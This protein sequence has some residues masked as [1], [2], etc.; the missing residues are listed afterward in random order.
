MDLAKYS[1]DD[2]FIFNDQ[3]YEN[4]LTSLRN[5]QITSSELFLSSIT[6]V[7]RK[8]N[9]TESEI[10]GFID[11]Y[12]TET[13]ERMKNTLKLPMAEK[14]DDYEKLVLFTVG[15]ESI[16]SR[17]NGGIPL[18]YLIEISG[19][20]SCGK[21]NF[22]LTLSITIQLPLEFGGLGP[23]VFS[24]NSNHNIKTLYIP[25]ESP[26]PTQRLT[27][28]V[29][30]FGQLLE[31]NGI[32]KER[33]ECF[34][35]LDNVLTTSNVMTNLEEQ[36]H[37]LK[38][39]L[40]VML[41][42]DRS[43]KLLIIDSLTHH[44]RA[45]LSWNEQVNYVK[46]LC[47]YLKNLTKEYNITIIIANQVTDKPIKGLYTGDNDILW[48]LNSEYQLA[49]MAGW[50]DIGI[51]YRQLMRREGFIDEAGESFERLDYLDEIHTGNNFTQSQNNLDNDNEN[52][53]NSILKRSSSYKAKQDIKNIL[54]QEKKRLFD[55][56]FK[57]KVS[58]IGTRPA[59]G[60]NLLEF[61]DM[62][63]VLSKDYV[64]IFD[65]NLI[66]EFSFE[67]GINNSMDQDNRDE[68]L[69]TQ[70]KTELLESSTQNSKEYK[71][72]QKQVVASLANN[73]YLK[74]Y[75]FQTF[76]TLKCVFGPL[77]PAGET[78][79]VEFEIWKGGLRK[80]NR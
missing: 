18:G 53:S 34:P 2:S 10:S 43:I 23:S 36:D 13:F 68:S 19:K 64:P 32:P 30:N 67:L 75:N 14:I 52:E 69:L 73:S 6:S 80:Y 62:R 21:T 76:R 39:Q 3:S 22:L 16:D 58:G 7:S 57:V 35:K 40:P 41:S 66:D 51:I 70:N 46:S 60:L 5:N 56:S 11:K 72:D 63:I 47:T 1:P 25:T 71:I 74:N 15:D 24:S 38:Y 55:S 28:I 12:E 9:K 65:E 77:I 79:K 48:K 31:T 27:Q 37:I 8:L 26:L 4:I 29:E 33:K 45:Q 61:V 78:K 17:L 42:R 44:L 20:S 54:K 59:L 50:D 49:W